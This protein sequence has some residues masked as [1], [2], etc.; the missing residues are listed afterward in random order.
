MSQ[1]CTHLVEWRTKLAVALSPAYQ[2]GFKQIDSLSMSL[3]QEASGSV[4]L[5]LVGANYDLLHLTLWSEMSP[6]ILLLARML[7]LCWTRICPIRTCL[8]LLTPA[9]VERKVYLECID[10]AV[11]QTEGGV[12][13][14]TR[15]LV[16]FCFLLQN[17]VLHRDS[18]LSLFN[19][20]CCL[21]TCSCT[22]LTF[23]SS[24]L[25]CFSNNSLAPAWVRKESVGSLRL[26]GRL[27]RLVHLL[28]EGRGFHSE[29]QHSGRTEALL[30]TWSE[31][32]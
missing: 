5:A 22:P 3:R 16:G 31:E 11:S 7:I 13:R 25:L 9:R 17:V 27:M 20:L 30:M 1:C 12:S 21:P 15:I 18:F 14:G 32:C 24:T 4:F 26:E 10:L 29:W 28:W 6:K 19:G 2:C 23:L 8:P